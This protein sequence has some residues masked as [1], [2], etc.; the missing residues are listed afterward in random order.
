VH[1]HGLGWARLI[2]RLRAVDAPLLL[3]HHGEPVFT[4]RARLGHRAVRRGV[5][6][7]LFTGASEGHVQPWIDAGV[8]APD[9]RLF[10]VLEAASTLPELVGTPVLLPGAPSVLWV[11]RLIPG[12]DPVTALD[13]F[14]LALASL[15]DAQLHFLATDRELEHVV[16]SRI[17]RSNSLSN[18]VHIHPPVP[19]ERMAAWYRGA[20][21]YFS[22]SCHEGANYSLIESLTCGCVPVLTSIPPHRVVAGDVGTRF[23]VGDASAAARALVNASWTTREPSL[24]RS[25]IVVSWEHVVG[26]LVDAYGNVLP[27]RD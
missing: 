19:H 7:Y 21:I 27:Q 13:A 18:R 2:R 6:G 12:K 25:R 22:T 24:E 10:E 3:Q 4:G 5:A 1:V 20:D 16:R 14:E 11:G 15:P 17:E 9:A 26:Q 23:A 8:I